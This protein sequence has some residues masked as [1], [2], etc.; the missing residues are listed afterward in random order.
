MGNQS[1]IIEPQRSVAPL[2]STPLFISQL[3]Q[4]DSQSIA[5]VKQTD[6]RRVKADNGWSSIDTRILDV[7]D[8]QYLKAS[9]LREIGTYAFEALG[10]KRKYQ[11][12]ITNSWVM[13]H[14]KGDFAHSHAHAN[15]LIS[16]VYYVDTYDNSGPI[17][18]SK[19][20]KDFNL[21]PA[22]LD[23]EF[24]RRDILNA[25]RWPVLPK[26]GMLVLFP[27]HLEHS[28]DPSEADAD[29]YCIAFNVFV[30]G[31]FGSEESFSALE[32]L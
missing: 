25:Y 22:Y 1:G 16:G 31:K 7:P 26:N 32:I 4:P 6:M 23:W 12:Q 5:V 2:F 3:G 19:N 15:S 29:R 17:W 11:F 9:I 10:L 21:F 8:M 28:V 14:Q 30:K 24:E 13:K 27:S 18:F 20:Y